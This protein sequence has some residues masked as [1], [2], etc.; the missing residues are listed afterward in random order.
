MSGENDQ[1]A[2]WHYRNSHNKKFRVLAGFKHAERGLACEK[3]PLC[4]IR[5]VAVKGNDHNAFRENENTTTCHGLFLL[6]PRRD[7]RPVVA[8]FKEGDSK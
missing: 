3:M 8:N 5:V 1:N 7:L 6:Q 4:E 2:L